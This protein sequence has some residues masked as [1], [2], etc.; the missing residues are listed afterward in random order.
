MRFKNFT[1]CKILVNS[2]LHTNQNSYRELCLDVIDNGPDE[3][4]VHFV[5][6]ESR[7]IHV[8]RFLLFL[9]HNN[10]DFAARVKVGLMRRR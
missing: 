7:V 8:Q 9:T 3:F 6:I 5:V 10:L 1:I 2:I 4:V